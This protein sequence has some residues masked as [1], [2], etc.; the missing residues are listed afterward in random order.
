MSGIKS[1]AIHQRDFHPG[2]NPAVIP[3][4]ETGGPFRLRNRPNSRDSGNNCNRD[5][6]GVNLKV[7]YTGIRAR[8]EEFPAPAERRGQSVNLCV[9]LV[10]G[11]HN[12]A[13]GRAVRVE[14]RGGGD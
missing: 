6:R 10:P 2:R 4:I 12:R 13:G 5:A 9:S 7:N 8:P 1:S 11:I 3:A 14:L